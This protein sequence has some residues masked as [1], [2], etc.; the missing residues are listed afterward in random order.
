MR[1]YLF[2]MAITLLLLFFCTT[3]ESI[4]TGERH[5]QDFYALWYSIVFST[6]WIIF[7]PY[8]IIKIIGDIFNE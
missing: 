2:G 1:F 3:Y 7:V 5:R 8:Y 4:R 6:L